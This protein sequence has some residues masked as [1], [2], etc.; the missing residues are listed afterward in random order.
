MKLSRNIDKNIDEKS[1]KFS[2][3]DID[4]IVKEKYRLLKSRYR[5]PNIGS[6]G[7]DFWIGLDWISI[8]ARNPR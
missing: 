7:L 6:I 3:V 5:L 4:W 1:I 2:I 8:P